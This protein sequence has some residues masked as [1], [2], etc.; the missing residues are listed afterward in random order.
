MYNQI[1]N[2]LYFNFFSHEN[3]ILQVFGLCSAIHPYVALQMVKVLK[4]QAIINQ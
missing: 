4:D 2:K 3:Y 1:F